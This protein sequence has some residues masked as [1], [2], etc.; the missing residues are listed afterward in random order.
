M[1]SPLKD[2]TN[3]INELRNWHNHISGDISQLKRNLDHDPIACGSYADSL[4]NRM[5]GE[6]RT[7]VETT[8]K[9]EALA[10]TVPFSDLLLRCKALL[11]SN[12]KE[13]EQAEDA[14]TQYGYVLPEESQ[15]KR[16]ACAP[17]LS[18]EPPA[19]FESSSPVAATLVAGTSLV[20][21]AVAAAVTGTIAASPM[22]EPPPVTFTVATPEV[23][24]KPSSFLANMPATPTLE[25]FGLSETTMS[26]VN[27]TELFSHAHAPS[28]EEAVVK[29]PAAS[30]LPPTCCS[31][32]PGNAGKRSAVGDGCDDD[33]LV[34][35]KARM[36]EPELEDFDA[37]VTLSAGTA[38]LLKQEA[39]LAAKQRAEASPEVVVASPEA[40]IMVESAEATATG[41]SLFP[42]VDS[43][44]EEEFKTLPQYLQSMFPLENLNECIGKINDYMMDRRFS[45]MDG[46]A[47]QD[48]QYDC[49]TQSI[50]TDDLE[51]GEKATPLFHVL[52][53]LKRFAL[54]KRMPDVEQ[55]LY[56]ISKHRKPRV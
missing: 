4:V 20:A 22:V 24:H 25:D 13:F 6:V 40:E 9:V 23:Q 18:P 35:K 28:Q 19:G 15:A 31:S 44:L 7:L 52:K 10:D 27:R 38:L 8:T 47:E 39:E 11:K 17:V 34:S 53:N 36:E 50:L 45:A 16:Q 42:T 55:N 26:F 14:L 30:P 33:L 54:H 5:E 3:A 48:E 49:I 32:T 37:T 46:E 12:E 21:A 41:G 29:E 2:S 51:Y 56:I 1:I 43:V